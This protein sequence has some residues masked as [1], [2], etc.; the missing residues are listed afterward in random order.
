MC[1]IESAGNL[2]D[3]ADG[4][5]DRHQVRVPDPGI[6]SDAVDQSHIDE[7]LPINFT[8]VVDRNDVRL[9]ESGSQFGFALKSSAIVSIEGKV[10]RKP[11]ES[12]RTIAN[13]VVG[14]MDLTHSAAAE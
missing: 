1:R 4:A 10:R 7:E 5:A 11:L 3:D 9:G 6:K 2:S 14:A 13:R 8:E 12:D